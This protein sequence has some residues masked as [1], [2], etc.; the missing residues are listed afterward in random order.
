MPMGEDWRTQKRFLSSTIFHRAVIRNLEPKLNDISDDL[1]QFL[2]SSGGAAVDLAVPMANSAAN[3]LNLL[4]FSQKFAWNDPLFIQLRE[5]L[6]DYLYSMSPL[7]FQ[8][9][10]PYYRFFCANPLWASHRKFKRVI[11]RGLATMRNIIAAR[12]EHFDREAA[13][14][15]TEKLD[16]LDAFLL[17]R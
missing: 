15:S 1:L 2:S 4:L 16:V 13:E 7:A 9:V 14:K 6:C 11:G 5:D 10:G 12:L 17:K 3:M 8:L